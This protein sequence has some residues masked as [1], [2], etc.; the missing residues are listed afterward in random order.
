MIRLISV[1]LFLV[2]GIILLVILREEFLAAQG[3]V[4]LGRLRRLWLGS[5]NRRAP[6][7]RVDWPVRYRR[8]QNS[9]HQATAQNRDMSATGAGLV[10]QEYLAHGQEIFLEFVLPEQ[11]E[12]LSI[13]GEV[14]WCKEIP[15]NSHRAASP[16]L[17]LVGIKFMNVDP[18]SHAALVQTLGKGLRGKIS[19]HG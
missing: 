1:W 9:D 8:I 12:R 2:A 18:G 5:E 4:P 11:V 6:R 13:A 7:Y 16:R 14:A 10:I 17:F 15:S 3:R 19:Q